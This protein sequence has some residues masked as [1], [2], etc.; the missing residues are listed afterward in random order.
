MAA[1]QI[2]SIASGNKT[3]GNVAYSEA[4]FIATQ[5]RQTLM[6]ALSGELPT[7]ASANANLRGQTK[8]EMPVVKATDLQKVAGDR[9]KVDLLNV[10]VTKPTMGDNNLEGRGEKLSLTNMDVDI[11][12]VRFAFNSG[13]SAT[14]QRTPHDLKKLALSSTYNSMNH[15]EDQITQ[16][17]L[18]GA[19]GAQT[20]DDWAAVPLQ[21]DPDFSAITV[22]PVKAP[23]YNRHFV[24]S[25]GGIIQGGEQ[26]GSVATTDTFKLSVID[27]LTH[28]YSA[29]D[30]PMTR[31]RLDGDAAA[32]DEPL[33]LLLLDPYAFSALLK[34]TATQNIRDFQKYGQLRQAMNAGKLPPLLRGEIYIWNNILVKKMTRSIMFN[35]SDTTQIITAANKGSRTESAQ[36]VNGSLTAGYKVVR[37]LLLGGQALVAAWGARKESGSFYHVSE[38]LL[39]HGNQYEAALSASAGKAKVSF[40]ITAS[41]GTTVPTDYGVAVI[42]SVIKLPF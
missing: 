32:D 2:A 9:L 22:N 3:V 25:N 37:S 30:R 34:D 27:D 12:Q 5:R 15:Y 35:P 36:V 40:D 24:V 11:N 14:Q 29:V 13:G 19:R 16:V 41:D 23:T 38:K 21:S 18:S 31:I 4:L 33:G 39:D 17:Q 42:D 28:L 10:K 6:N 26:L 8:A 20:G 1:S 7:D